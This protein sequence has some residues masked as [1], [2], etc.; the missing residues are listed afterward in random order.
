MAYAKTQDE[1]EV[2]ARTYLKAEIKKA[3]ITYTELA[4]TPEKAQVQGNRGV[5]SQ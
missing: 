4:K 3:D 1:W 2:R 5:Y